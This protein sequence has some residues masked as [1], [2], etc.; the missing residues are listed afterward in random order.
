MRKGQKEA[1][2]SFWNIYKQGYTLCSCILIGV[3]SKR[4]QTHVGDHINH[5]DAD[6]YIYLQQ[7]ILK[8]T[9]YHT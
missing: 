2:R 3:T 6:P 9:N 5:P 1:M 8:V 4:P 7:L